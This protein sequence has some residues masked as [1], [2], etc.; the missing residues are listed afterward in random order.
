MNNKGLTIVE[1]VTTFALSTVIIFIL[2]NII[3]LIKNIYTKNDIKTQLLIEQGN[4]SEVINNKLNEKGLYSYD[5]CN[6]GNVCYNFIYMEGTTS[7]LIIKGDVIKFD[8]YVS[9]VIEGVSIDY[10]NVKIERY[11]KIIDSNG[12]NDSLIVIKVPITHKL[13]LNEDFGVSI[14]YQYNTNETEI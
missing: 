11:D 10:S 8:N 2:I 7:K 12:I 5:I 13:Y 9:K 3:V 6:E 1:L 14:V 4:L